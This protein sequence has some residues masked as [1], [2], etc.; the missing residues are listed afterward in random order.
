MPFVLSINLSRYPFKV[1]LLPARNFISY[2]PSM[3]NFDI[4]T[5]VILVSN[6]D[7]TPHDTM[8][9]ET[10]KSAS[11]SAILVQLSDSGEAPE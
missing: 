2:L 9:P 3:P 7:I 5:S 8:I 10:A 1:I 6:P 4:P 11:R